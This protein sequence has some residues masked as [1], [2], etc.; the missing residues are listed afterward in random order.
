MDDL[1]KMVAALFDGI[2]DFLDELIKKKKTKNFKK[3][4]KNLKA[5]IFPK[6]A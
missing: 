2:F 3:F 6:P 4:T 5:I 1:L